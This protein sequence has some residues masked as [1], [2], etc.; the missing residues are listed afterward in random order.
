M[1]SDEIHTNVCS[2]LSRTSE[3]GFMIAKHREPCVMLST[4]CDR[5]ALHVYVVSVL[6]ETNKC[7]HPTQGVPPNVVAA[8][9]RMKPL[10]NTRRKTM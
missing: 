10:I 3:H 5:K 1:L 2:G 7:L 6:V 4:P 9:V 8:F